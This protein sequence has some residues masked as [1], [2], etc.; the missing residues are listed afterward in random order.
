MKKRAKT[1]QEKRGWGGQ[2][3]KFSGLGVKKKFR[4]RG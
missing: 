1:I 2:P 3:L 4:G